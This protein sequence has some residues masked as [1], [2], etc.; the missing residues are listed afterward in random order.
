[1][2]GQSDTFYTNAILFAVRCLARTLIV[3]TSRTGDPKKLKHLTLKGG[4][5]KNSKMKVLAALMA[6]SSLGSGAMAA[7]SWIKIDAEAN[8]DATGKKSQDYEAS[9]KADASLRFEVL[10]REGIKAVVK[11]RIEQELFE[12]GD[13]V[14]LQKIDIDKM[15]EQAYIEIETDKVSGLPRAILTIGKQNMAFGQN[16]TEVPM[17]RDSLLYNLSAEREMI[18]LTVTLPANFM[19]IVDSVAISLYETGAGDFKVSDNHGVSIQLSKQL[20]SR[21]KAQVSALMKQNPSSS[22]DE[23]RMSL[24][25]VFEPDA[26]GNYKVWAQGL[27]MDHNP[28]YP[29]ATYGGQIGGSTK[30]GKGTVVVEYQYL[31]TFAQEL[32]V[33]YNLPVGTH[34][35]VSPEVRQTWYSS[36][37]VS[38]ET[39][40]G[41]RARLNYSNDAKRR[42]DTGRK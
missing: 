21:L 40:V 15:V 4:R 2:S 9:L 27:V 32:V 29:D 16:I 18:G 25:F 6:I 42:L 39:R 5:M 13:S 22:D 8:F 14:D 34:L 24:G 36:G 28:S 7:P 38:E 10:V 33:A 35:L 23:R 1:M 26:A 37:P 17:F 19:K 12:A 31:Q 41:I 3:P 30:L 20:S 11:A